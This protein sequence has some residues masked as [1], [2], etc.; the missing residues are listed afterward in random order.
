[1][2]RPSF[3]PHRPVR[4][5]LVQ[6]HASWVFLAGDLVYKLKKP[7]D[8]GFLDFSTP[9]KRARACRLEVELNRRLAPG[10]YVGTVP[11]YEQRRSPSEEPAARNRGG[12]DFKSVPLRRR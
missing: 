10:V 5:R 11:V 9:A 7:V 2:L 3:Y 8:F 6:T 1:M 4:V 12:T